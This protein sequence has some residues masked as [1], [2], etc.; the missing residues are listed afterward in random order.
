MKI[1]ILPRTPAHSH[2]V[3]TSRGRRLTHK[4]RRGVPKCRTS[5]KIR[6]GSAATPRPRTGPLTQLPAGRA[7]V[8]RPA[9]RRRWAQGLGDR[10][11]KGEAGGRGTS[12]ARHRKALAYETADDMQPPAPNCASRDWA[13]AGPAGRPPP[14]LQAVSAA[15]PPLAARRAPSCL[16]QA[17]TLG[18]RGPRICLLD[19]GPGLPATPG[20]SRSWCF[21]P[22][23]SSALPC[24]A[25]DGPPSCMLTVLRHFREWPGPG[26]C[27]ASSRSAK[28]WWWSPQ[29]LLEAEAGV[30]VVALWYER[31]T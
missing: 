29:G 21:L 10:R 20:R 13:P 9:P 5:S 17:T 7:T 22:A 28:A 30:P 1:T 4:R 11:G 31:N 8:R 12:P 14:L 27:P 19:V 3:S 24:S 18:D 15:A 23:L 6:Q 2:V 26:G 16:P 25:G